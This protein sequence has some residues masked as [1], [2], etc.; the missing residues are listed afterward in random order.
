MQNDTFI[1]NGLCHYPID[2]EAPVRGILGITA[3]VWEFPGME[4]P[5]ADRAG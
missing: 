3:H 2:G 4:S 5:T 1:I